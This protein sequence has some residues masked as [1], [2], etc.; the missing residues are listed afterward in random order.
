MFDL[1]AARRACCTACACCAPITEGPR[2]DEDDPAPAAP[3]PFVNLPSVGASICPPQR[4]AS[5]SR[6][7]LPCI[8]D[9]FFFRSSPQNM[10]L[11]EGH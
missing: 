4:A 6:P 3:L 10:L 1:A 11:D 2:N 8:V 7:W 9:V 5:A